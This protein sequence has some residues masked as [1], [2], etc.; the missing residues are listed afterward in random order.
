MRKRELNSRITENRYLIQDIYSLLSEEKRISECEHLKTYLSDNENRQNFEIILNEISASDELVKKISRRSIEQKAQDKE[1]LMSRLIEASNRRTSTIRRLVISIS[2]TA[3]ALL[4]TFIA[5]NSFERELKN[6]NS[7]ISENI[8]KPTLILE[9]GEIISLTEK[10]N[11]TIQQ[12]KVLIGNADNRLCY[13]LKDS[14][15]HEVSVNSDSLVFNTL[16]VPTKYSYN[17]RL[18][19]GTEVFLNS[20]SRIK[21]PEAFGSNQREVIL[22]GE[23]YFKVSKEA[24]PFI[25]KAGDISI[26]VYGTEFNVNHISSMNIVETVLAKGS[27]GISKVGIDRELMLSPNQK[28][29]FENNNFDFSDVDATDYSGWTEGLF[30]YKKQSLKRVLNDLSLWYGTKFNVNCNIDD[31]TI[32]LTAKRTDS[33]DKIIDFIGTII[34]KIIVKEGKEVYTI[35]EK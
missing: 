4:I 1:I 34:D 7:I 13:T 19:D 9:N 30:R 3:A 35:E 25:V 22:E 5:W 33:A 11:D 31:V 26:R 24:R 2:A 16:V 32:T 6:E 21:Y 29:L 28:L 17:M 23:A 27:V 8:S 12:L 10:T 20:G 15:Q 18:C 14:S